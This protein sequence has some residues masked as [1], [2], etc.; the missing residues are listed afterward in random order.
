MQ[1]CYVFKDEI[2]KSILAARS[3]PRLQIYYLFLWQKQ[4]IQIKTHNESK[5]NIR[6]YEYSSGTTICTCITSTYFSIYIIKYFPYMVVNLCY[7]YFGCVSISNIALNSSS[8]SIFACLFLYFF[9][10]NLI[11]FI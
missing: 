1:L 11:V 4:A 7:F 6:G 10:I 9:L 2:Q 3:R 5:T 8:I